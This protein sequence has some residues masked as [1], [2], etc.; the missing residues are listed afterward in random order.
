MRS[1]S[2]LA[3]PFI[4]FIVSICV[5]REKHREDLN[6]SVPPQGQTEETNILKITTDKTFP[7][8]PLLFIQNS[9]RQPI[10]WVP[11]AQTRKGW[12]YRNNFPDRNITFGEPFIVIQPKNGVGSIDRRLL[13]ERI[14][15]ALK[16]PSLKYLAPALGSKVEIPRHWNIPGSAALSDTFTFLRS[17]NRTSLNIKGLSS[18]KSII[19]QDFFL[20]DT[21]LVF[22]FKIRSPIPDRDQP[23]GIMTIR[24]R[25]A[26][27]VVDYE[28]H[29]VRQ[30]R[31]NKVRFGASH[32]VLTLHPRLDKW[33]R[34]TL[35]PRKYI[36][37]PPANPPARVE[38]M[39]ESR[40]P[41]PWTIDFKTFGAASSLRDRLR[42]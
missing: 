42:R 1:L 32:T 27:Q 34:L 19:Y 16:N 35:D 4:L 2:L 9:L 15:A 39:V 18:R 26:R 41:L 31:P 6:I 5:V 17:E 13:P 23:P 38:L 11:L 12:L 25:F 8:P 21:P 30:T 33:T 29:P 3:V 40:D 36:I 7:L 37:F 14:R 10:G 24:F 20:P 28:I 22:L